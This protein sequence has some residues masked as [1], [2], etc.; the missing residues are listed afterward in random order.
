[1][2]AGNNAVHT[3]AGLLNV[4]R[5]SGTVVLPEPDRQESVFAA[6]D[7]PRVVQHLHIFGISLGRAIRAHTLPRCC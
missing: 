2:Q 5:N 1:M 6:W 3:L 4:A 7:R